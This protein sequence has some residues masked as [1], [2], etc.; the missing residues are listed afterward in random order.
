MGLPVKTF[1]GMIACV[2]ALMWAGPQTAAALPLPAP[3][4]VSTAAIVSP[5]A[6]WLQPMRVDYRYRHWRHRPWRHR[7]FYGPG[8][9]FWFG[10][11]LAPYV[12]VPYWR[13]RY[14]SGPYYYAP[15]PPPPSR[16]YYYRGRLV[17]GSPEWYAYCASKYR[18]FNPRTGLYL[19]YS[20]KYWRCR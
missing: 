16:G 9:S 13:Y 11:V 1:L 8:L 3:G 20:G 2:G 19:A 18:N 17:A 5:D 7:G 12:G 14:Q 15:P 6:A 4:Q 10:S